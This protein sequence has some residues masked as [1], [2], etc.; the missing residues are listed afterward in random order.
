[1]E[2]FVP[3]VPLV[4]ALRDRGMR[5]R[6]WDTLSSE[7]GFDL[8]PNSTFTLRDATDGLQLHQLK[9]LEVNHMNKRP[10]TPTPTPH[11]TRTHTHTPLPPIRWWR[12]FAN[13][14]AKNTRSRSHSTRCR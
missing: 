7:L 9:T 10:S 4:K 6:H 1:M 14:R 12:E 3:F 8:H 11:H 13:M 2:T 5:A